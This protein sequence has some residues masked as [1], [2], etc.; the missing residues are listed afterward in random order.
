MGAVR[1]RIPTWP[2]LHIPILHLCHHLF[3]E[4]VPQEHMLNEIYTPS[5]QQRWH[6]DKI[7]VPAFLLLIIFF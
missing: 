3:V 6:S 7:N 4:A 5:A 2:E 1:E